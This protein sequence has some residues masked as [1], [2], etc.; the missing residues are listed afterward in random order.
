MQSHIREPSNIDLKNYIHRRLAHPH[1]HNRTGRLP[2]N[3]TAHQWRIEATISQPQ[4]NYFLAQ[5]QSPND[6]EKNGRVDN[7]A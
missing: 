2:A 7:V 4:D 3:Y 1:L 6:F 5:P